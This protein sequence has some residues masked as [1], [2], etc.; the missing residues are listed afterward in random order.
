MAR[1]VPEDPYCVLAGAEELAKAVPALDILDDEEPAPTLLIERARACEEAARAVSGVTN[2]EGAEASWSRI[3][4]AL[5]TSNGFARGYA[6]SGHSVGVSRS[7]ARRVGKE[8]VS[9]CRS[10][11][12]PYT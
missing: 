2:S 6:R 5:V 1:V 8:W 4:I 7:E 11:W 10:R 9:T 3:A 12:S